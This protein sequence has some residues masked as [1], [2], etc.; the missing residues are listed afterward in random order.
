MGTLKH[1]L[2]LISALLFLSNQILERVGV[3]IPFIHSYLDDLLCMPVTLS[4]A[5]FMQ[6]KLAGDSSFTFSK[7]R[8]VAVV[9]FYAIFFELWLPL[10][11][12][13]YTSD[14]MDVAA[15][16]VGGMVFYFFLNHPL[17]KIKGYGHIPY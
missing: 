4:I 15:Y 7:I 2:F 17:K 5:L 10:N 14:I 13:A 12:S 16:G 9:M 8:V 6:Q 1:P 11:S 3:F